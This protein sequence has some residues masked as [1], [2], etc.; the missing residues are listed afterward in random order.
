MK[1]TPTLFAE[2]FLKPF[3]VTL[4]YVPTVEMGQADFAGAGLDQACRG[5][6]NAG[7]SQP[8]LYPAADADRRGDRDRR[9][10]QRD[11]TGARRLSS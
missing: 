7:C 6:R 5:D 11:V 10:H 8:G 3:G 4:D 2:G 9:R 1:H